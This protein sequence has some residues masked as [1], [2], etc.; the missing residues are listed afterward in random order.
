[1]AVADSGWHKQLLQ[2]TSCATL[3]ASCWMPGTIGAITW[4][5]LN[6]GSRWLRSSTAW[7]CRASGIRVHFTYKRS[8]RGDAEID[9]VVEHVLKES[10]HA[11]N[12]L[13]FAPYGYDERQY[14]SPGINLPVGCL[15]ADPK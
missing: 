7:Y 10:G 3:T 6:E 1:M 4:L 15:H 9:R 12:V 8:R 11:F 5:A 13:D 2:A 14:C